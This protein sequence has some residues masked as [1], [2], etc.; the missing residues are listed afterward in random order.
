MTGAHAASTSL[1]RS[2]VE[3]IVGFGELLRIHGLRVTVSDVADAVAILE[4]LDIEQSTALERGLR[5]AMVRREE[6]RAVFDALLREY[7][8]GERSV[9]PNSPAPVPGGRQRSS[10]RRTA[11]TGAGDEGTGAPRAE[12]PVAM[13]PD[14]GDRADGQSARGPY[15]ATEVFVKKDFERYSA[16]DYEVL[17]ELL[18]DLAVVGPWRRS[19]RL[20]GHR[21]GQLDVR[22]TV[23]SSLS[24]AGDPVRRHHRRPRHR[25]RRLTFVLDVSGSME[26]YA[27]PLLHLA[28]AAVLGR[29]RVEAFAFATGLTRITR[30]LLLRD[31]SVALATAREA[32]GDWSG[33]TRIGDALGRLNRES[34][35]ATRGAVVIIASDGWDLGDGARLAAEVELLHR[36]AYRVIWLNPHLRDPRFEPLTKGMAAALPHTDDFVSC[37]N[38]ESFQALLQLLDA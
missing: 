22:R 20:E 18:A 29:R 7:W 3:R 27:R 33:G 16:S 6:D 37:H 19:R 13:H 17:Q 34:V 36:R 9:V 30:G 11:A 32:V 8:Y 2:L 28:H 15:S 25:Q 14:E 1:G 24:S 5:L 31:P 23:R 4:L 12:R 21:R 35:G 38:F 10:E 26:D